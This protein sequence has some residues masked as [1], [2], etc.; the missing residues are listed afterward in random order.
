MIYFD[1]AATTKPDSVCLG[2]AEKY[3][4]DQFYNPSA[5]YA[6]GYNL[7][8]D[9]R[10]ARESILSHIADKNDYALIITSCGSEADNQAVFCAGRRG[11]IVTTL[12]EHAAV[13]SAVT[14]AKNRGIDVRFAKLNSDGSVN[15]DSLLSLTDDKTSLVSV[16][17]VNNETGA[18]ND[19][20]R[21]A[22]KVKKIN[23]HAVF[24][25]DGVQAFGKIPYK[26]SKD[27]DLYSLS[28][29]KIGAV[30]GTGALIYRK[31]MA[32]KPFIY[33]GGQENGLRSG[34][35]NV[36]GIKMLEYAAGNVY[37]EIQ[38]NY[39]KIAAVK[40]RLWELLDKNIFTLLSPEK[41]SPYILTVAA[42]GV[43]GET[44]LHA[45]NDRGLIIGTGSA[46]S[47]NAVKRH[48]RVI[49]A[50]EIADSLA[51]SVLRISFC[52]KNT[53]EQAKA[54]AG[55]LNK[56]VGELKEALK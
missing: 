53:L 21:L 2:K 11:N 35:E 23:P 36:F 9:L 54:A 5:L 24:H 22:G 42:S 56:T 32:L 17:H 14:E 39:K 48:S 29:H 16:I 47:S 4:T 46:C 52:H 12:G 43:R 19:I 27:I 6:E 55:I 51:D 3:L 15:E 44:A 13:Y 18:V 40:Q 26:L 45:V 49:T 41:G 8:L 20:N 37:A 34:T 7:H 50:C 28:A 25:S 33:G 30:K 10:G 1:N 38:E 31:K